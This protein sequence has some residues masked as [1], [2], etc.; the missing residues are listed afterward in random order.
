MLRKYPNKEKNIAR[1]LLNTYLA[2]RSTEGKYGWTN[3]DLSN[4]PVSG[5]QYEKL[6]IVAELAE[7][8]AKTD[9]IK[10]GNPPWFELIFKLAELEENQRSSKESRAAQPFGARVVSLFI[11]PDSLL[12]RTMH[13]MRSIIAFQLK[14][15]YYG[16]M[17][18]DS[19]IIVKQGE[20]KTLEDRISIAKKEDAP[21][22]KEELRVLKIKYHALLQFGNETIP[23]FRQFFDD[24]ILTR[25]QHKDEKGKPFLEEKSFEDFYKDVGTGVRTPNL[26]IQLEKGMAA[27]RKAAVSQSALQKNSTF[28]KS[29]A[30]STESDT[31]LS[32]DYETESD[33]E[34]NP[35]L[36]FTARR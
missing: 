15:D 20:I 29:D 27:S 8:I 5:V 19:Q 22:L 13:A 18:F 10:A 3:I 31:E 16:D 4:P 32:S 24:V 21:R 36:G 25:D 6:V 23:Y 9:L 30:S 7:L 35:E 33:Y 2:I 26:L 12:E 11:K 1:E 14:A 28:K 17:E 34:S